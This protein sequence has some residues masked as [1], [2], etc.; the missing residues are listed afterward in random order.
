MEK[1]NYKIIIVFVGLPASGK[2]YTSFHIKQYLE[3]LGYKIRIF[4]CGSYRRKITGGGQNADFFNN[5]NSQ[6][7]L[8]REYFLNHTLFDLNTYL[9][10]KGGDI[11]ILDATNSTK[12]RRDKINKFFSVFNYNKKI[13]FIENITID[14]N[15]I[16][17]NILFKKVSP[18][19]KQFSIEEM[20][21]DFKRRL[22]YYRD[23]YEIIDDDENLNYIKIYDCGKKV[24]YNDIYGYVETLILNFLINFRVCLK[25]IYITRHGQSL[26][27]LENRIGGDPDITEEGYKY[28][29]KLYGYISLKYKAEEIIIFTSNLKRTKNTGHLFI[30]NG[31]DVRHREILNE[32]DGGV[33]EN[34]TY[35]DV[36]EKMPEIFEKRKNDKFHFKYPEGESYYDLI[37]R[38][39]AFILEINRIKKPILIICHNAIVRVIYSYFLSYEH[40]KIP[41]LDIPLHKLNCIENK[42]YIYVKKNIL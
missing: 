18:D 32:I 13:I 28:A 7:F 38:L 29:K 16:D 33:C 10:N 3:W 21:K 22:E 35:D 5:E 6:Y 37:I 8:S 31:Y 26:Y 17:T 9:N 15:I 36:K 23:V 41:H 11:A 27:N 4:N 39:K 42:D 25:K 1:I 30:K 14:Q 34:M 12:L 2:S 20:K 19:Y 24:T 40:S